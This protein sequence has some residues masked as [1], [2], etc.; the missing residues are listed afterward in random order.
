VGGLSAGIADRRQS[1][2]RIEN[3]ALGLHTD[4]GHPSARL[5][6]LRWLIATALVQE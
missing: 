3:V 6:R 2:Q 4:D 5:R 1:R